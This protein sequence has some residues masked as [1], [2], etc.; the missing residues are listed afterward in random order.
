MKFYAAYYEHTRAFGGHEEGG[1]WFS[2]YYLDERFEPIEVPVE[3][4]HRVEEMPYAPPEQLY[5]GH[6]VYMTDVGNE[7]LKE[8]MPKSEEMRVKVFRGNP[9]KV[10]P[11]VRPVYC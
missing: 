11:P 5:D 7:W 2:R 9:P 4:I 3:F 10:Y 8:K 1:W 6:Y